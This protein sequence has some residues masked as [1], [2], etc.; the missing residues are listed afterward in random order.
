VSKKWEAILL[1]KATL[2]EAVLG[3]GTTHSESQEHFRGEYPIEHKNLSLS[4]D[5]HRE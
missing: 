1:A 3:M 2:T 4:I 5:V